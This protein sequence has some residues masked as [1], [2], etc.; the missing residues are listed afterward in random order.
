MIQKLF[1]F[2]FLSCALA[3]GAPLQEN[4]RRT[5]FPSAGVINPAQGTLEITIHPSTDLKDLGQGWPF[6]IQLL[7]KVNSPETR[8]IL[9]IYSPSRSKDGKQYGLYALLR[10]RKGTIYIIDR[11][12]SAKAGET[13]HL[14][15][16]WGPKGMFF[17]E[18]GRRIGQR[19]FPAELLEFAPELQVIN[20][21]P[22]HTTRIK[23][24][25]VQLPAS[26]LQKNAA[27]PFR[28]DPECTLL[29]NDLARPQFFAAPEI[30]RTLPVS[31]IPFDSTASKIVPEEKAFELAFV[32]NNLTD[33]EVS[34]PVEFRLADFGGKDSRTLRRN[35]MLPAGS[36]QKK[37]PIS[38][39]AL[40]A[41][42]YS[43]GVKA[44]K[45]KRNFSLS[46]LPDTGSAPMG[47]LEE[48]LGTAA[49]DDA[50]ILHRLGIRWTR[51]WNTSHLL[52][53]QLEPHKGKFDFRSAD[54]AID[55]FRKNGVKVLAVLGYPPFWAAEE[56]DFNG[57]D[58][59]LFERNPGTWKPRS[60]AEWNRYIER[61]AE[62]FKGRVTH[63]EIWNEVDWHPPKRAASFS[64]TTKEYYELLV[65]ASRILHRVSP[66]NRVLISG[67]GS[68]EHCDQKMPEELLKLGVADQIDAWNLHAYS[69]TTQAKRHKRL[70]HAVKPGMPFWQSEQMWHVIQD[71]L[72]RA[73]LTAAINFWFLELGFE[74]YF[75]FGWGS[76]LSDSHTESP[77]LPL[78]I[79]G[80][81]QKYL[82]QCDRFSARIPGLPEQDFDVA[83]ALQRTD[84]THL[85][86]LGSS[87]GNYEIKVDNSKLSVRDMLGRKVRT[88]N[89]VLR[90]NGKILY[91]ISPEPLKIRSFRQTGVG[92]LLANPGFEDLTGDD[93][94]GIEKCSF[95]TWQLRT[96]RDPNGRI[97]IA[98]EGGHSGKYAARISASGK[99]V[100]LFSYLR[101]PAPGNYRITA[102]FRTLSGSPQP[103][104]SLFD[105][106]P[107]SWLKRKVFPTPPKDR[108]IKLTFDVKVDKLPGTVAAIFGI[109]GKGE[110][111]LDDV[112]LFRYDLPLLE[113]GQALPLSLP[114][115]KQSNSLLS[116][117]GTIHL[118]WADAIGSGRK[119]IAGIPFLLNSNWLAA[120]DSAWKNVERTGSLR[121]PP[122]SA[123]A[124]WLLG[125]TMYNP[126]DP[127]TLLADLELMYE[128]GS[129]RTLPIRAQKETADW[130]LAGH[131]KNSSLSPGI[132]FESPELLAY[133]LFPVRLVN[134]VPG[135]KLT[136]IVLKNRNRGIVAFK[137]VTLEKRSPGQ[138]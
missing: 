47:K 32:G 126:Q 38:L 92:Q 17:Y 3:F 35:V 44:G 117:T 18:N 102:H 29:A 19:A 80:V 59:A 23:V 128:D 93:L 83:A 120:A 131:R 135:K 43:V 137:A 41:G 101:L 5:A 82:R 25:A 129:T 42:F 56:P 109:L 105:T 66:E 72:R 34:M 116:K 48:Y 28:A 74:K 104:L 76:F 70:V 51:S 30:R 87:S 134:P 124:V 136:G 95:A 57:P 100:Y 127:G 91:V 14:A 13:V 121:F 65:N 86:V 24:S 52:W 67:F 112:E 49:L 62:H 45:E 64:G 90:L 40:S 39:P 11:N 106:T 79:L 71:P 125:A 33:K 60:L 108:F 61:T 2:L 97:S 103:Y 50:A 27:K 15:I 119:Q 58:G 16:T 55:S 68:G 36:V 111:L 81:C 75:S 110:V 12:P 21:H 96:Q 73:Y 8:T 6:A 89:G 113:E 138:Q 132:R 10:T 133:G 114:D 63:Y 4:L 77:E 37:V 69:V 31:L 84:G 98:T 26:E 54:R 22:F 123:D 99:D 7:G 88:E 9:G 115:R 107:K 130:F 118:G 85:S 53:H 1:P 78:H 20:S 122:V 94:D 46:V